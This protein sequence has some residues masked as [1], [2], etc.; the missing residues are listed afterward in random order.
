MLY[1]EDAMNRLCYGLLTLV[2]VLASST[3]ARAQE[4]PQDNLVHSY[5]FDEG[6]EDV[7]G[8]ADGTLAGV[9]EVVSGALVISD[10]SSWMELPASTIGINGYEEITLEILY[11]PAPGPVPPD[12]PNT[13]FT[14]LAYFGSTTGGLGNDYYFISTARGDDV[15]RAAISIGAT[16]EP[17][18]AESGANGPEFDDN[19]L[20][21]MVSTLTNSEIALY[22]DGALAGSV[23]LAENN[24]IGGIST[25]FAYLA[26]GGYTSD[27]AWL[28][29]IHEFNIYDRALTAEEISSLYGTATDVEE[30][31]SDLPGGYALH[32]NY[33]NPFNPATT[34][35]YT[36]ASRGP[37]N[38]SVHDVLGNEVA[39]LVNRVQTPGTYEVRFDGTGLSSGIY[40]CTMRAPSFQSTRK[41]LLLK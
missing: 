21:H 33:P 25:D 22:L 3:A 32:Q 12:G 2:C 19:A 23:P 37:V 11:T 30:D 31:R 7:V 8:G 16:V 17:W 29:A 27:P 10:I 15:S 1:N 20:H 35:S 39:T 13:G 9:A 40:F 18:T 34:V 14:M 6:P 38:I 28:G 41:L 24:F 4:T 5:T 36:V 26:R